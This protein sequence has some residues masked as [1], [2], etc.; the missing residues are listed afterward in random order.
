MALDDFSTFHATIQARAAGLSAALDERDPVT[1]GHCSRVSG[2]AIEL[3]GAC[4]LSE[5]ELRELVVA[6]G[7][8]D[9]GKIGIPDDV[10]KKPGKFDASDWEIMRAHAEKGQ[11]IVLASSLDDGEAIGLAVRHHHERFD[12]HGYPDRLDGESIPVLARIIAVVDTYDAM[13]SLRAYGPARPHRQIMHVLHE[14]AGAQHDPYVTKKFASLIEASPF[15]A[16]DA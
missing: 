4:A 13:A 7:F 16:E 2:L 14:V 12:G 1:Y 15:R 5:R 3:G 9:V 8:H 10:L 6:A 11:R